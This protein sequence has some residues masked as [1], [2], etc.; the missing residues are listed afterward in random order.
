MAKPP[1]RMAFFCD[2]FQP[3]G[4]EMLLCGLFGQALPD[5][6]MCQPFRLGDSGLFGR[7]NLSVIRKKSQGMT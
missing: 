5:L 2:D 4:L 3:F 6:L 7:T 1:H